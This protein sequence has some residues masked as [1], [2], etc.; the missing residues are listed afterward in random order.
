[1]EEAHTK[2][3]RAQRQAQGVQRVR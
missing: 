3:V 1:L 2:A